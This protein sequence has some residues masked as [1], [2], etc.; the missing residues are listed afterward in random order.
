[1]IPKEIYC[2]CADV[3][4]TFDYPT[5]EYICPSCKNSIKA[6]YITDLPAYA[7]TVIPKV[8]EMIVVIGPSSDVIK[9]SEVK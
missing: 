1:M 4:M 7:I 9:S 8:K 2:K 3:P 5:L 6:A